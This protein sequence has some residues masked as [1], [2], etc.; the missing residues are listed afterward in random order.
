MVANLLISPT[1]KFG[2]SSKRVAKELTTIPILHYH[3]NK[4]MFSSINQNHFICWIK[5]L[6]TKLIF[7]SK[8][9]NNKENKLAHQAIGREINFCQP[10]CKEC[11]MF[12]FIPTIDEYSP[13]LMYKPHPFY[14]LQCVFPLYVSISS[15]LLSFPSFEMG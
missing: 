1:P 7:S 11:F 8:M 14:S 2:P 12:H 15:P 10:S 13:W 5:L 9:N 3:S 6:V 4:L